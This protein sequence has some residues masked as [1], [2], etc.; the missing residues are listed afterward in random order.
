MSFETFDKETSLPQGLVDDL[1]K[2]VELL[3]KWQKQINLVSNASLADVWNRHVLDSLQIYPLIPETA[4]SVVD[5]GSG[6]GFPGLIVALLSKTYGGPE[7]HLIE[8]DS[9]KCVFLNEVNSQT[10]AGA[11]IHA[12]RVES[13]TDL[14]AD[15][16]TAR[17]LAPLRKLLK[18]ATRFENGETT[19]VFLKGE[20]AQDELTEAQKDWTMD[21]QRTPSRTLATATI[22]TLKG[23]TRRD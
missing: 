21:V 18:L 5:L 16:V 1:K 2:Y 6:S 14:K 15:V 20:K 19:Y 3:V 11:I 13:I 10:G 23:L 22:F 8:A 17:A 7:V 9:R 12:R 4:R